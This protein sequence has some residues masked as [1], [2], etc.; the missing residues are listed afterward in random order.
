M[1]AK[2]S[3]IF[4]NLWIDA[5]ENAGLSAAQ[6]WKLVKAVSAL[7]QGENLPAM[8]DTEKAAFSFLWQRV[9]R[10]CDKWADTCKK[11]RN[12]ANKRWNG[13]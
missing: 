7:V 8:T 11:R 4:Y 1:R 2:D 13:Q 10:D 6:C 12:A 5:L 9:T 3:F